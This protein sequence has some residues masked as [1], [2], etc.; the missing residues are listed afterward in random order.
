MNYFITTTALEGYPVQY[1][2][3]EIVKGITEAF[4]KSKPNVSNLEKMANGVNLKCDLDICTNDGYSW[5]AKIFGVLP[6]SRIG[7]EDDVEIMFLFPWIDQEQRSVNIYS[8][9]ELPKELMKRISNILAS[10]I[11]R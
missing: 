1:T 9:S 2:D 7:T 4:L 11:E 5:F 6:A 10:Y 3:N 8:S